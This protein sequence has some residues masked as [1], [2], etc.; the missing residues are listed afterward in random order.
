VSIEVKVSGLA[1]E[2]DD[3][4]DRARHMRPAFDR[5]VDDFHAMM[6][7]AFDRAGATIG[8]RWAANVP[9]WDRQKTGP[10]GVLTGGLRASL[11]SSSA[12]GA[13]VDRSHNR[14][15]LGSSLPHAHLFDAGR[16]GQRA[17]R[18]E[19][20]GATL[21]RWIGIVQQHLDGDAGGFDGVI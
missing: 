9:D 13:I 19:P 7:G 1:D 14:V 8:R 21:D 6:A 10:V 17:R 11:T 5:V 3:L 12:D 4:R 18:L 2:L 15:R 20:T 16:G